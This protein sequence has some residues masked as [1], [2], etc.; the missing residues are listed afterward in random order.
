MDPILRHMRTGASVA[1]LGFN[2]M[3]ALIQPLGF[4]QSIV[5]VGAK[6][7]A[8]G[9]V[10]LATDP[11]ALS[12]QILEKSEMMRNRAR[13]MNR[14]LN[15]IRNRVRGKGNVRIAIDQAVFMPMTVMQSIVDL[16]TWWGA[17]QKALADMPNSM[18]ADEAEATAIAVADQAVLASQTGGQV[19]D[20]AAIQRGPEALKLFT[21]FYGYFSGTYNLA[22]ER[23]RATS[24]KSPA[25]VARLASDYLLLLCLPAV[26]T[27][28]IYS[29]FE[30]DDGEDEEGLAKRLASAQVSYLFGMMVGVREIS[31]AA[32]M[33]LGLETKG[34]AGYGGPAGLRLVQETFRLGQQINQGELDRALIRSGVNVAG[35][36]L[37]LP[38][39]QI[40]RTV[41]GL[42][43][44]AEGRAETPLVLIGGAPP[45]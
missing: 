37:H 42:I 1:G 29:F 3:N 18:D 32:Q 9:V 25:Q 40:N 43:A 24:F 8:Q 5:R 20:L 17:Y 30:G 27:E 2:L 41:D 7:V 6:W 26:M 12:R 38:S 35:I 22:V 19:K 23:T 16:P 45:Q 15:D 28:L 44:I 33:A 4:A 10:A 14:E 11:V 34:G 31:G 36:A 39:G 13:T 21:T